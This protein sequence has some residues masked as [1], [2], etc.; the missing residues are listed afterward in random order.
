[1]T[2]APVVIAGG[3]PTGLLLASE[4]ALAGITPIVLDSLPGPNTEHRANG[5]GGPAV[6]FL[7]NRGLYEQL[8]GSAGRPYTL[9]LGMF[10]GLIFGQPAETSSN[11]FYMLPVHQ[12]RLTRALAEHAARL[13]ANLRWGHRLR[14]FTQDAQGVTVEVDGPTGLYTINTEYLV[15]ADGGRS[16]TRKHAEIGFPGMSSNDSVS[17]MGRGLRPPPEWTH[18]ATSELDIPGYGPMPAVPFLRTEAG[19]FMWFH[20]RG[21]SMVGTL[22]LAPAADDVRGSS[23]HPGFGDPLTITELEDSIRRVLGVEVPLQPIDPDSEPV[24]RRFDGINSRI[25]EHYRRGRVLLAGDAAHVHSPIGGPGLNLCLQDAANLG[26]KLANVVHGRVEATV[27]DT[28]D[29]ERRPAAQ[30]VITH[31]RAQLALL[32]PGPEITALREILGGLLRL[33]AVAEDLMVTLSGTAVRYPTQS[34]DHPAVGYWMP[35]ITI[36]LPAHGRQRV[37][38]LARDGR[39][40]LVDFTDRSVFAVSLNDRAGLNI[41][42]GKPIEPLNFTA[43]LV[44]PDGYVSWASSEDDPAVGALNRALATWFGLSPGS[45]N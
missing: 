43:A 38:Q 3:G 2:D 35:D 13:G 30:N 33:P 40:L 44:R 34:D 32:R 12:P 27:L 28:Y 21:Q 19:I 4:L 6:R 1:M 14:G 11:Q 29:A 39:P 41:V 24:L 5:I 45:H 16:T 10:G 20:L 26:W 25:A 9:P 22:E 17:R 37:A 15:G 42:A 7:D 31:S 8:S 36:D 23:D 18:S